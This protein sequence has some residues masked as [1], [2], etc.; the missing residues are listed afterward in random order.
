MHVSNVLLIESWNVL[1]MKGGMK[2]PQVKRCSF[3]KKNKKN[4][5]KMW[6]TLEVQMEKVD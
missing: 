3:L 4:K 5:T 6:C 1:D 2:D